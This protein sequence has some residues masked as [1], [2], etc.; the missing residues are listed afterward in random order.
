MKRIE[1]D[2][3]GNYGLR[4][5]AD[6][7]ER[8]LALYAVLASGHGV[9]RGGLVKWLKDEAVWDSVSP[10]E[11]VFLQSR[12]IT[13]ADV[14]KAT[15]RAEA[16]MPLVWALGLIA[17]LRPPTELC[18]LPSLR[19]VLPPIGSAVSDFV[20]RAKLRDEEEIFDVLEDTFQAHWA[21]RDAVKHG[22]PL[23][24]AHEAEVVEERHQALNWLVCYANQDWDDVTT[25]T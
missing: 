18:D 2:R 21:I 13:Q 4:S 1:F 23:A 8:C 11:R 22:K 19:S 12:S 25:D 9:A 14:A 7:A 10:E 5:A 16:L 3:Q 6:V 15:W 17:R 24:Y 20:S